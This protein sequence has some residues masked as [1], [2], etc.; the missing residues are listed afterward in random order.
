MLHLDVLLDIAR[1]LDS[2]RDLDSLSETSK[3]CHGL[4]RKVVLPEPV[5]LR[6]PRSSASLECSVRQMLVLTKRIHRVRFLHINKLPHLRHDFFAGATSLRSLSL[7]YCT[8]DVFPQLPPQLTSLQLTKITL[9][10]PIASGAFTGAP[11][12]LVLNLSFVSGLTELPALPPNLTHLRLMCMLDD[13]TSQL[14][15]LPSRLEMLEVEWCSGHITIPRVL[16]ASIVD[17]RWAAD[18]SDLGPSLNPFTNLVKL[19]LASS[20]TI[21]G[22]KDLSLLQPKLQYL[23]I[24]GGC[25]NIPDSISTLTNLV[26]LSIRLN[27]G[28]VPPVLH[29]L[30]LLEQLHLDPPPETLDSL[31]DLVRLTQLKLSYNYIV[32]A[33]AALSRL[34]ALIELSITFAGD[35]EANPIPLGF[36]QLTNL[37]SLSL[38]LRRLSRCWTIPALPSSLTSL[39]ANNCLLPSAA[40]VPGLRQ[41]DLTLTVQSR[42]DAFFTS[43]PQQLHTSLQTLRLNSIPAA[44]LPAAVFRLSYLERLDLTFSDVSPEDQPKRTTKTRSSSKKGRNDKKSSSSS[45]SNCLPHVTSIEV[46]GCSGF[47]AVAETAELAARY[48]PNLRKLALR[49]CEAVDEGQLE[50]LKELLPQLVVERHSWWQALCRGT[51]LNL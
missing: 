25:F 47:V 28:I 6:G 40:V 23:N 48:L 46:V 12:L 13:L 44:A 4:T 37:R 39:T 14:P 43:L 26:N 33:P 32:G 7:G 50:Q 38:D 30:R 3:V 22:I 35:A 20:F 2:N 49:D 9:G 8:L 29:H 11:A 51:E 42:L 36:Q 24:A 41:L 17:L 15:Q 31:S 27:D 34:T 1:R 18:D 19:K 21:R 45:S 10:Q 5:E 16:P